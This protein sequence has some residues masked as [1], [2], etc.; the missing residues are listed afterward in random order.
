VPRASADAAE[1]ARAREEV[2]KLVAE[3]ARASEKRAAPAPS[4]TAKPAR[5]PAADDGD[6]PEIVVQSVR[7]HPD[8]E[9]RE[10]RLDLPQVGPIDIHEGDIVSGMLVVRIDPGAVE[11][12]LGSAR[13]RLTLGP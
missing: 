9:R 4:P 5:T 1:R 11:L 2:K 13:R 7:W 12:Q 10:A 3:K 6:F 8:A